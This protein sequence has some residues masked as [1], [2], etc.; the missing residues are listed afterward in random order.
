MSDIR[1]VMLPNTAERLKVSRSFIFLLGSISYFFFFFFFL[2]IQK[3]KKTKQVK[4]F[5][6]YFR[7]SWNISFYD[8]F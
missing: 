4:G 5:R 8:L 7:A 2:P 1:K 3:G 6:A